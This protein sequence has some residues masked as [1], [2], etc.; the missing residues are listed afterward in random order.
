[1]NKIKRYLLYFIVLSLTACSATLPLPKSEDDGL[2][3]IPSEGQKFTRSE[4]VF[5]YRLELSSKENVTVKI[6]NGKWFTAKRLQAGLYQVHSYKIFAVDTGRSIAGTTKVREI[7]LNATYSIKI[8]P[9]K[10][11][12]AP[13]GFS[14]ETRQHGNG[15][16]QLT[17][18]VS[19]SE[20]AK[21]EYYKI[22][23]KADNFDKWQQ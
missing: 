2:L 7:D 1:M 4:F 22:I 9:D 8:T 18:I 16:V 14:S 5:Q 12:L 20:E 21:S 11:T 19:V 3:I 15:F 13:F 17:H 23:A 10:I 6:R